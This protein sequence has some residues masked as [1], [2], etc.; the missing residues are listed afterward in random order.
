MFDHFRSDIPGQVFASGAGS[1]G[2]G[3]AAA[4]G[5]RQA[6][7]DTAPNSDAIVATVIGDG[8][9]MFGMPAASFWISTHYKLPILAIV[10]NNGGPFFPR[11]D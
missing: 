5:A 3:L 4:I 8:S 7:N 10:L 9:Y 1:L 2:W 11:R 6:V